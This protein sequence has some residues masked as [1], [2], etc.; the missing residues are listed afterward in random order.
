VTLT[1][2]LPWAEPSV[3]EQWRDVPRA[4]QY[5]IIYADPPWSHWG[6]PNKD[7]AAGKHYPLMA[8][9]DLQRLPV[10][11]LLKGGHGALF[12]WATC[13]RLD[14]AIK[15]IEAWD[16]VY[17]GVAFVWVK[18]RRDG[19]I[20][21]GQG[22]PPT[23][24]KPLTELCLLGTTNR[25]GRPFPLLDAAVPQ[26]ILAARQQHSQ[27]PAIVR[28][29]IVA[30]YGDRPRIELFAREAAEGWDGWGRDYPS[31]SKAS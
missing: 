7:A 27:K 3:A 15:T 30:L 5:D 20:I 16:F 1:A 21:H 14:L 10:R 12:C 13:P 24:T 29:H 19:G 31:L 6:D 17:R 8:D 18:T 22:I 4:G 2:R 25:R 11:S 28:E 26:T 23:A 9:Q